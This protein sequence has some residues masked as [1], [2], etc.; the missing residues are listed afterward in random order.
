MEKF[1]KWWRGLW[2]KQYRLTLHT[3][4]GMRHFTASTRRQV[5][6]QAD[7]CDTQW[8]YKPWTLYKTGRFYIPE[9]E[10]ARDN[11]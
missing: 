11:W 4:R 7:I 8:L 5:E 1:K 6:M 10:I 3:P 9:R 2:Q